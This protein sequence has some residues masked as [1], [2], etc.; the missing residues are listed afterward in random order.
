MR[1][2]QAVGDLPA[3][4]LF[5]CIV[6]GVSVKYKREHLNKKHQISEELYDELIAKKN[7][8]EDI[9]DSLP[10]REVHRCL[11]CDREC[12][13]IKKHIERSHQVL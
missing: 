2:G 13:D 6:C 11:V 10:E 9:S 8:G 1:Q 12:L 3:P 4:E 5:E 7:R